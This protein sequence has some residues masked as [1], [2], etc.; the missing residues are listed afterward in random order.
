MTVSINLVNS[1]EQFADKN[2]IW[3]NQNIFYTEFFLIKF[4]KLNL[5]TSSG[6]RKCLNLAGT[7]PDLISFLRYK[8]TLLLQLSPHRYENKKKGLFADFWTHPH[9]VTVSH[10]V[11]P[12]RP[13]FAPR[14][15][16]VG[17]VVDKVALGQVFLRVLRSY[18]VSIIPPLLHIHSHRP[19]YRDTVSPHRSDTAIQ[20]MRFNT[21][22]SS[23]SCL[24]VLTL[25]PVQLPLGIGNFSCLNSVTIRRWLSSGLLP[26]IVW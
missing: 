8:R 5:D 13:G 14:S 1:D 24:I 23:L 18:P 12:W 26:R 19:S 6:N 10:T 2:I 11:P 3:F 16:R 25:I 22:P 20:T 17:F 4:G 15:V 7:G 9:S 21:L